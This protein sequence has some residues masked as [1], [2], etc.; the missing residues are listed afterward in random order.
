MTSNHFMYIMINVLYIKSVVICSQADE[1][2]L[3]SVIS[4]I[5]SSGQYFLKAASNHQFLEYFR[6]RKRPYF[7]DIIQ[8]S[9]GWHHFAHVIGHICAL[10]PVGTVIAFSHRKGQCRIKNPVKEKPMQTEMAMNQRRRV[11]R[12]WRLRALTTK[13]KMTSLS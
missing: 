2:E 12:N 13:I 1:I 10:L 3:L 11:L 4:G 5:K 7:P 9:T 6:E 8:I